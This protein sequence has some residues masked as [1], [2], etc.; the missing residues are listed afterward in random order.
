MPT[1]KTG[2]KAALLRE[3]LS[4]SLQEG[5]GILRKDGKTVN[6][7]VALYESFCYLFYGPDA[8]VHT[9]YYTV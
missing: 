2:R 9:I 3:I 6:L 7:S 1:Q 8:D 4:F 5:N